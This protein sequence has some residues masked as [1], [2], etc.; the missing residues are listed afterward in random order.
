MLLFKESIRFEYTILNNQL[1]YCL[2]LQRLLLRNKIMSQNIEF[3]TVGERLLEIAL[4]QGSPSDIRK[5][6]LCVTRV[7]PRNYI[8]Q[9]NLYELTM[10]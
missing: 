8:Q 3:L 9:T 5:D 1:N 2:K 10:L 4:L 6:C 7:E